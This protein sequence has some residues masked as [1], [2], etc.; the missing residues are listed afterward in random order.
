M[1]YL[2]VRSLLRIEYSI[3]TIERVSNMVTKNNKRAENVATKSRIKVG[4]LP[5][6]KHT[7]KELPPGKQKQVKGGVG[8]ILWTYTHQK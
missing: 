1:S 6:N 3:Q 5:P 8:R 7:I 2:L 4:K